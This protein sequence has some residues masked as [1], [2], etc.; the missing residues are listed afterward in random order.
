[1]DWNNVKKFDKFNPKQPVFIRKNKYSDYSKDFICFDSETS[2]NHDDSDKMKNAKGWIYQWCFSYQNEYIYGRTPQQFVECLKKISGYYTNENQKTIVFVHNLS[3]DLQYLKD[4]LIE[5]FGTSYDMLAIATHKFISFTIKGFEFRCTLKLSNRS[6]AKWCNDLNTKHKKLVGEIDYDVIRYQ[7]TPLTK[8]DWK[9]ML[10]DVICL[11]EC[12]EKEMALENDTLATLPLTSTG[13]VRRSGR[14]FFK[15]EFLINNKN[16]HKTELTKET[17][18]I[19]KRAFS[20]A[21]THANRFIV[22]KTVEGYIRHRDFTS[23]YPSQQRTKKFPIGKFNKYGENL[24]FADID[25]ITKT[26]NI[27]MDVTFENIILKDK[28]ESL[29]YL[30]SCIVRQG[31]ISQLDIIEDNGR[32]LKCDGT[33]TISITELDLDIIR[34]QY[35]FDYYNIDVAYSSVSGYLPKW[36]C[37]FVD[38]WFMKKAEYKE[39]FKEEETEENAINLM[40]S[41]NCLNGIYGMSATDIVRDIY[42]MELD[43]EWH[44]EIATG[45]QITELLQ[46]YYNSRNSFMSFQ[47]G[48]YTTAHARHELMEMYYLVGKE[49]FLYADTDSIFY[50]T[51]KE[52]ENRIEENN[53]KWRTEAEEKGYFVTVGSNKYYYHS[54]DDEKEIIT[55]FRTLHSKCYA[56]KKKVIENGK[57]KKKL[58]VTI[59]GVQKNGRNRNTRIKELGNIDELKHGKVFRDCGGTRCVYI[60]K[61]DITNSCAIILNTEKTLSNASDSLLFEDYEIGE[62]V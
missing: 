35:K 14:K 17:Y 48:V 53:T 47:W 57:E 1:M 60:E 51:N 41:K 34:K 29:P 19:C 38:F 37:E 45:E 2:W 49:N 58:C 24:S 26:H 52:I 39:K 22:G 40:K 25:K 27:I 33:F 16:F 13:Y 44:K 54:F 18:Q 43:G 15:N 8:S 55:K 50:L 46:K 59:A 36:F 5:E 10:Y 9:Y 56:Y 3:Y 7:Y 12:V 20:G 23:H 32:I 62:D 30:Q 6:L 28:K 11:K 4:F 61:N 21:L 31:R 42:T